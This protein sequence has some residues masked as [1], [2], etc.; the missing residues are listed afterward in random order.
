M[1]GLN[2]DQPYP[3]R[4]LIS[5]GALFAIRCTPPTASREINGKTERQNVPAEHRDPLP[6]P[7]L[8]AG[9]SG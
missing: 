6:A 9:I 7:I 2:G 5:P 4:I 3:R 1:A 8:T